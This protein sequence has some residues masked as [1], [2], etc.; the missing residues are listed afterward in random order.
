MHTFMPAPQFIRVIQKSRQ[1]PVVLSVLLGVGLL[2]ALSRVAI[3]LPGTPVP[4]TGQTFGVAL[5]ALLWGR[6]RGWSSVVAYLL[7]GSAGLPLFAKASSLWVFGPTTGYLIGML[8]A[9]GI[10][11]KLSD[12]GYVRGF[13][14]AWM[15]AALGSAITFIFGVGV[16]SQYVPDG[17]AFVMGWFPFIPGDLI[18]TTLVA[19]IVA[20]SL[21]TQ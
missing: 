1:I 4:V 15:V 13:K 14:S 16:L 9:A 21:R 5:L 12:Q 10:M 19:G 17:Q 3:P 6:K 18:K 2:T 8:A 7:L 20:R 11:G